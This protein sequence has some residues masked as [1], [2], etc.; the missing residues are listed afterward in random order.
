[1]YCSRSSCAYLEPMLSPSHAVNQCQS[2]C[3]SYINTQIKGYGLTL[4]V[5]FLS[6]HS[7]DFSLVPTWPH[8]NSIAR[9]LTQM[10]WVTLDHDSKGSIEFCELWLVSRLPSFEL[11]CFTMRPPFTVVTLSCSECGVCTLL[12]EPAVLLPSWRQCWR[13]TGQ[14]GGPKQLALKN[15]TN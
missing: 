4:P 10:K 13:V 1:M 5:A 14:W 9:T 6:G 7:T 12:Q 3:A 8:A 2:N 11:C 15:W